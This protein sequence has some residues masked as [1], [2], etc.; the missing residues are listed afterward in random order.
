MKNKTA[1]SKKAKK[2]IFV[3]ELDKL[4][5]KKKTLEGERKF[6]FQTTLHSLSLHLKMKN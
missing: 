5:Q 4:K 2:R 6:I 1:Q 3:I